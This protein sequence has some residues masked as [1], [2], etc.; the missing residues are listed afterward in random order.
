[1][2]RGHIR[3]RRHSY[4]LIFE[5]PRNPDGTRNQRTKTVKGGKR[6]AQAELTRILRSIDDGTYEGPTTPLV[7][8]IETVGDLIDR[9]FKDCVAVSKAPATYERYRSGM[10]RHLKPRFGSRIVTELTT[11]ELQDW[12]AEMTRDGINPYTIRD[13]FGMMQATLRKAVEWGFIP[14]TPAKNIVMPRLPD[15]KTK[16]LN[17]DQVERLMNEAKGTPLEVPLVIALQTGMRISEISG[18]WDE[19]VDLENGVIKVTQ[20]M[21]HT[22]TFGIVYRPPKYNSQRSIKISKKTAFF[23]K[24]HKEEQ[25]KLFQEKGI[26]PD[27]NQVCRRADGRLMTTH[28]IQNGARKLFDDAGLEDFTF[29]DLRHTHATRLLK[30]GIKMYVLQRRLG[31]KSI[32]TTINIYAHVTDEDEDEAAERAFED[33]L[34]DMFEGEV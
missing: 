15:E 7:P 22:P 30:R 16:Y 33:M 14:N 23:L 27:V 11:L 6:K 31:H 3:T 19:A 34:D 2:A 1:M 24:R 21:S 17:E 8:E 28:I 18:L 5:A 13:R 4:Q 26:T 20:Q 32:T 25:Q 9:Y 12:V 10:R 29:H